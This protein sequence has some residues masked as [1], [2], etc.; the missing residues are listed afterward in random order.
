M[1]LLVS[2]A[3]LMGLLVL[4]SVCTAAS[5]GLPRST[6]RG[7]MPCSLAK[8]DAPLVPPALDEETSFCSSSG[9]SARGGGDRATP[10]S[11]R[12]T[13]AESEDGRKSR[14]KSATTT[15][16]KTRSASASS[17]SVAGA[18]RAAAAAAAAAATAAGKPSRGPSRQRRQHP[19]VPSASG[20]HRGGDS[21]MDLDTDSSFEY[22]DLDNVWS[23]EED[24]G[25]WSDDDD[26]EDDWTRGAAG[27][28][29]GGGR[30]GRRARLGGEPPKASKMGR[31]KAMSMSSMRDRLNRARQRASSAYREAKSLMSSEMEGVVLKATRPD[32]LPVKPKHLE[33]LMRPTVE[34]PKEFNVY[35]PVVRKLWSKMADKEWRVSAKALYILHR[36]A[37]DGSIEHASN[38]KESVAV[39]RTHHD[40]RRKVNYFDMDTICD[41]KAPSWSGEDV[42]P[43]AEFLQGYADFVLRRTTQFGPGFA[44]L[45]DAF[46][47]LLGG[48]EV[49]TAV[50]GLVSVGSKCCHLHE[51]Q[52]GAIAVAAVVQVAHDIRDLVE[53]CAA[54]LDYLAREWDARSTYRAEVEDW[55]AFLYENQRPVEAL[56]DR[57]NEL[58]ERHKL[59]AVRPLAATPLVLKLR[60]EEV[61][62]EEQ[63][64]AKKD[65]AA[66]EAEKEQY[67]LDEGDEEVE[68]L[69][70]PLTDAYQRRPAA[71]EAGKRHAR[72]F[73]STGRGGGGSSSGGGGEGG[74]AGTTSRPQRDAR[75]RKESVPPPSA[76]ASAATRARGTDA[77]GRGT[78]ARPSPPADVGAGPTQRRSASPGASSGNARRPAAARQPSG[79]GSATVGAARARGREEAEGG[80]G[81]GVRKIVLEG[82]GGESAVVSNRVSKRRRTS[83]SAKG[84]RGEGGRAGAPVVKGGARRAAA[85]DDAGSAPASS[86]STSSRPQS[87]SASNKMPKSKRESLENPPRSG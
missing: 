12:N 87:S 78:G 20:D 69:D 30:A 34:M 2:P 18:P 9:C 24:D 52:E 33:A 44:E 22:D 54:Q 14:R 65:V 46:T 11:S 74:V 7:S 25:G 86:S 41:V 49:M 40:S 19:A 47:M 62:L 8:G 15:T 59:V 81:G 75:A 63:A 83:S 29:G 50:A 58:A 43:M 66:L 60:D 31:A 32:D 56:I 3:V 10:T 85:D 77:N 42:A 57:A 38:L 53:V 5:K 82:D 84:R 1:H 37:A 80:G 21:G 17:A 67:S 23:D 79:G 6:S 72:G 61:A 68:A 16:T 26:D 64:R 55:Y 35:L 51:E 48:G 28:P 71:L 70:R 27:G 4:L 76:S 73:N 13:P 36:F 39:L 45:L